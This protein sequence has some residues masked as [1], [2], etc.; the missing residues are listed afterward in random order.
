MIDVSANTFQLLLPVLVLPIQHNNNI[1]SYCA[2]L[3]WNSTYNATSNDIRY[4]YASI[5]CFMTGFQ[6]MAKSFTRDSF[7]VFSW[8]SKSKQS[9]YSLHND[10][11]VTT[12]R[13]HIWKKWKPALI[14]YFKIH[15]LVC[16][17]FQSLII[18]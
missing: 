8:C 4:I 9:E 17:S 14:C 18:I 3:L 12:G 13:L 7:Q 15:Q 11:K 16:Y 5:K 6:S 2:H 10:R 1:K